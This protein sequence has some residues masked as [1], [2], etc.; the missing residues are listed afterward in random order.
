M[1]A[2]CF[3][4]RK[5]CVSEE[6]ILKLIDTYQ[7]NVLCPAKGWTKFHE[8]PLHTIWFQG[9]GGSN[10]QSVWQRPITC[11]EVMTGEI[12]LKDLVVSKLLRQDFIKYRSLFP[13]VSAAPQLTEEVWQRKISWNVAWS[14]GN[15]ISS[16]GTFIAE[17]KRDDGVRWEMND[18]E[19]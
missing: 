1:A 4:R 9:F 2:R 19:T 11:Y 12:Q 6:I 7:P 5:L 10:F 3:Y 16:M 8:G 18:L 14:C 13:H 15:S 17:E